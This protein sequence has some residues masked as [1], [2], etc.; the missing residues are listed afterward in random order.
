MVIK[1][2]KLRKLLKKT[3]TG[4]NLIIAASLLL[5]YLS[6]HINPNKVAFPAFFGLAYPYLLLINIFFVIGWGVKLKKE[7]LI[8]VVVILLGISH[9]NNYIQFSK[10]SSEEYEFS[11]TSYNL[12]LFNKYEEKENSEVQI[13]ALIEQALPDILCFQEFYPTYGITNVRYTFVDA[14]DPDYNYHLKMLGDSKKSIFGI[15]TITKFTIINRGDIVHPKSASLT[16]F[17]DLLIGNDTVRVYNN[18]LQSFR[19]RRM[20][21]S[22]I[23]EIYDSDENGRMNEIRGLSSTLRKGF[24]R[25]AG[26]SKILKDHIDSSPYP[27]IVCGDFND[28]PVS[29]SYHKIRNGLK[30]TFVESGGG[31]G[32]T[33]RDKYPS[34]RIDYILYS[35]RFSCSGFEINRVK[36]SDHYPITAYFNFSD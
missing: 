24:A 21:G 5:S 12:R 25:R 3:V 20:E 13:I 16:I 18:H 31:A 22:L 4:A 2:S 6:A 11:I 1:Q 19:L 29:F 27:V 23:E 34:N 7:I 28:T 14:L 17:T 10:K 9:F 8:S 33:Y 36:Y 15:I 26:Q 30:D 35:D 32:F